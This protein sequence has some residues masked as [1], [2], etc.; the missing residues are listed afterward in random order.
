MEFET[1]REMSWRESQRRFFPAVVAIVCVLVAFGFARA[2]E[3]PVP[4][5]KGKASAADKEKAAE[6]EKPA[7]D[8]KEEKADDK[9]DTKDTEKP[10]EKADEKKAVPAKPEKPKKNTWIDTLKKAFAP[11]GP[12]EPRDDDDPKNAKKDKKERHPTDGRAPYD[13]KKGTLMRR[14]AA[15]VKSGQ[16]PVALDLLQRISESPE[17]ALH[18]RDDGTWVSLRTEV[19]RLRSLA[20]ANVLRDYRLQFGPVAQQ[21]LNNARASG[22]TEDLGRVIAQYF[23]T[24]AGLEAADQLATLQLDRGEFIPAARLIARLWELKPPLTQ[25]ALWRLRAAFALRQAGETTLSDE[26]LKSL[27][28]PMGDSVNLAGTEIHVTEWLNALPKRVLTAPA[29]ADWLAFFG[30]AQRHAATS[31]GEPLLLPRW[32]TNLAEKQTAQQ[33]LNNLY[34][35]LVDMGI[36]P[37]PQLSP[38]MVNGKIAFRTLHGVQVVD[39]LSGRLQWHTDDDLRLEQ[40]VSGQGM[41]NSYDPFGNFRFGGRVFMNGVANFSNSSGEF[42]ALC[43]LLYR[44]ANFGL[45]S[46]DGQRLFVLEDP[47]ILS[48]RSPGQMWWGETPDGSDANKLIAYDL[49]T[50]RPLWEIGGE[51]YGEAFEPPLAGHFFFGP[52]IA[53][54]GELLLASEFDNEVRLVV[55]DPATGKPRWTQLIGLSEAGIDQDIGRRWWTAQAACANGVVVIPT[56]TG[57]LMAVDRATHSLLWGYRLTP[58]ER[59]PAE[60]NGDG[61]N[62]VQQTGLSTRWAPAPPVIVGDRVLV[63][64]AESEELLC[65]NLYDGKQ[66]W[67]QARN[68]LRTLVGVTADKVLVS[69]PHVLTAFNLADGKPAWSVD[70]KGTLTAGRG[71]IAGGKYYLPLTSGELWAVSTE[72]GEVV[73]KSYTTEGTLGNLA[74]YRGMLLS[75]TSRGLMAFEQREA[76]QAEIDRRKGVNPQDPWALLKEADISALQ[77]DFPAT[78]QKLRSVVKADLPA[79]EVEHYRSLL[80]RSLTADI[81]TKLAEPDPVESIEELRRTVQTP[82]ES[83]LMQ[84]LLAERELARKAYPAAFA[85]YVALARDLPVGLMPRTGLEDSPDQV[86]SDL[87]IADQLQRLHLAAPEADRATLDEQIRALAKVALDGNPAPAADAE[88]KAATPPTAGS[89]QSFLA[90]FAWHPS[91]V[92]VR[93]RLIDVFA[94]QGDFLQAERLLRIQRQHADPAEQAR[95]LERQARLL[96]DF[97]DLE[98]ALPL[99]EELIKRFPDSPE[100]QAVMA[101]D[102]IPKVV[103]PSLDWKVAELRVERIGMNYMNNFIQ[104]LAS[105]GDRLPYFR[106]HRLE[107]PQVEQRFQV[108]DAATDEVQWSAP[109]RSRSNGHDGGL[110]ACVLSGHQLV[111]VHQGILQVLSPIDKRVLWTQT[112][113]GRNQHHVYY[114]GN[115]QNPVQPMQTSVNLSQQ[116]TRRRR[117]AMPTLVTANGEVI[118][119]QIRRTVTVQ[120]SLTGEVVWTL[121]NLPQGTQFLGDEELLY[122]RTSQGTATARRTRDGEPVEIADLQGLLARA[123][124]LVGRN[125]ILLDPAVDKNPAK[126]RCFD[127]LTRKDLWTAPIPGGALLSLLD[128]SRLVSLETAT[129]AVQCVDLQTGTVTAMGTIPAENLKSRAETYAFADFDNL[130]IAVNA[131]NNGKNNVYYSE[132]L[133]H[134]RLNGT[135]FAFNTRENKLRWQQKVEGQHLLLERLDY[136]PYLVMASRRFDPKA[137]NRM[138]LLSLVVYD[139]FTGEK[140]L[141]QQAPPQSGFRNL[142]VHPSDHSVELRGYNERVRMLPVQKTAAAP[143]APPM[144]AMP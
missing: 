4:A 26:I 119:T 88:S 72:N 19:E 41:S 111:L 124:D 18:R 69:G 63:A 70:V 61:R 27:G 140:L 3:E 56:T 114:P 109:L 8:K 138:W 75:L 84:R 35:D 121:G 74:M 51:T 43:N 78:L 28:L 91:A 32:S 30:N 137:A 7:A 89:L 77:R 92:N 24:D 25:P 52:P 133:P 45:I 112:L 81:R 95:A 104:E 108:V 33:Q 116:D 96:V 131:K 90:L 126:L 102:K 39:A 37:L 38:I 130:Y 17:D 62:F 105:N 141:D 99:Y 80:V 120:D 16:W 87:W 143:E 15:A 31:G 40:M 94:E 144:P 34:D 46:S 14:A 135:L 115:F 136:S 82:T 117:V 59:Q 66:V 50:G 134:V 67:K 22:K 123:V 68:T 86:R 1:Q 98:D 29:L 128:D 2:D 64:A 13:P 11:D 60:A 93:W 79:D 76:V 65:I 83:L 100:A 118:V 97:K 122:I 21:A 36:V 5:E 132:G 110:A 142:I 44:N 58:Q 107:L 101:G 127:P 103:V 85:A 53:D 73:G 125:F 57:W 47:M 42:S 49:Q 48:P 6:A 9:Q 20:P 55:L 54:G 12:Q 139:K 129:G 113:D 10:A 71:M 23:Q 106:S